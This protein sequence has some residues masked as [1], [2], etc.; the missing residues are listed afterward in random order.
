MLSRLTVS[1][2]AIVESAED[3]GG[4]NLRLDFRVYSLDLDVYWDND[5]S[6]PKKYYGMTFKEADASPDLTEVDM[7]YAIVKQDGDSYKLRL[8]EMIR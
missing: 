3:V 1:N 4:G 7:G 5:Q 8:Y 6:I 2:L